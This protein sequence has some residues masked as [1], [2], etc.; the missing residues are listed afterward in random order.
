MRITICAI[1][2]LIAVTCACAEPIV[3]HDFEQRATLNPVGSV[4]VEHVTEGA[5]VGDGCEHVIFGEP[6]K[7]PFALIQAP[8]APDLYQLLDANPEVNGVRFRLRGDGSKSK[9]SF[10][11]QMRSRENVLDIRGAYTFPGIPL[12]YTDWR[13]IEIP[14]SALGSPFG[15]EGM[16]RQAFADYIPQ[17]QFNGPVKPRCEFWLD[18]IEL[19]AVDEEA[20][21]R[22]SLDGRDLELRVLEQAPG[23]EVRPTGDIDE[24]GRRGVRL[25]G[26]WDRLP[27]PM[28]DP[29]SGEWETIRVP[30]VVTIHRKDRAMWVVRRFALPEWFEGRRALLHFGAVCMY[31]EV[32]LNGRFLGSHAG[33]YTPFEFDAT[34]A[35]RPGGDNTLV[36]YVMD[37]TYAIEGAAALHQLGVTGLLRDNPRDTGKMAIWQDVELLAEPPVHIRDVWARPSVRNKELEVVI[38]VANDSDAPATFT[39]VCDAQGAN[40]DSGTWQA[41]GGEVTVQPGE[42]ATVRVAGAQ[43]DLRY[44]SPEDPQLYHLD[45]TLETGGEALDLHRIRF[46]FR[47]FWIEGGR[48]M[49]NGVPVRLLGESNI[50]SHS[51]RMEFWRK[52]FMLAYWRAMKDGL[53]MNAARVHASIGAEAIFDAADEVGVMLIDQSSIWSVGSR[54]YAAGGQRFLDNTRAEFAEWV[55]RDRNHPSVVIWDVENEMV[56]GNPDHWRW[57]QHLDGFVREHDDTRPIEHSGAGWC[58]GKAEIY[59]IHN[60]ENYTALWE[61]WAANPD[62][63]MIAGEW[64]VG[65][66]G[67]GRR[68]LAGEEFDS[69]DEWLDLSV[70][71]W[72]ERIH[73]QRSYGLSGIMPFVFSSWCFAP[74]YEGRPPALTWD[75]PTAADVQPSRAPATIDPGWIH[76]HETWRTVEHRADR[77]RAAFKPLLVCVRDENR[78]VWSGEPFERRLTIANDGMSPQ[79]VVCAWRVMRDDKVVAEGHDNHRV[80]PGDV[81]H[82]VVR[83]V[84]PDV[85]ETTELWL[86]VRLEA[87]GDTIS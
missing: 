61:A 74:L 16:P 49:L 72:V 22:R 59:H 60:N 10:R 43:G 25:N 71:Y 14:F 34:D 47:E 83:A 44:W 51:W 82:P 55:R 12:R 81:L 24:V 18:Q 15:E 41:R 28:D 52:D 42:V 77:F 33:A 66:R 69:Y 5:K 20:I 3:L 50:P 39:P 46:G 11:F 57:V 9:I 56:R 45:T 78:A 2:L 79:A 76:E 86:E 21:K 29:A 19:A 63:P 87:G 4:T 35:A 36:M 6:L 30:G 17:L 70:P 64:W 54:W 68:L 8:N 80:P 85:R 32:W 75:D 27:C 67:G 84:A 53:G 31:C 40:H 62:K 7:K 37:Q 58:L 23:R 65:G 26:M 73:E 1:A 13:L 48:F 38:E